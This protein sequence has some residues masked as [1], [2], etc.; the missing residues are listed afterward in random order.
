MGQTLQTA[1]LFF[2]AIL[3]LYAS[4]FTLSLLLK[5]RPGLAYPLTIINALIIFLFVGVIALDFGGVGGTYYV[6]GAQA[7][8]S[9]T[10]MTHRWL[11]IQLPVILSVTSL[12][13]LAAYKTRIH[14]AHAKH[15]RWMVITCVLV[16][17]F[18]TITMAIESFI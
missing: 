10:L 11:L 17:F 1:Q 6:L 2:G 7:D 18:A 5:E 16:G 15:Y 14:E 13:V 8:L 4:G 9:E 3:L 12:F